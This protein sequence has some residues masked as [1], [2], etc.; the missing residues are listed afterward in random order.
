MLRDSD[1][2]SPD[3]KDRV[4]DRV[5]GTNSKSGDK[6]GSSVNSCVSW[7]FGD[8]D[9]PGDI[10]SSGEKEGRDNDGPGVILSSGEKDGPG[11]KGRFE[12][13]GPP[14][15]SLSSG[16]E[17]AVVTA[18][19]KLEHSGGSKKSVSG[20]PGNGLGDEVWGRGREGEE[21]GEG[22]SG[23]D[24]SARLVCRPVVARSSSA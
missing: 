13:K 11:F 23:K 2:V 3:V 19:F 15:V 1:S 7:M 18:N 22:L 21:V 14:T 20:E 9:G 5:E 10:L 4:V 12:E 24:S 6:V 17:A 8:N 16:D